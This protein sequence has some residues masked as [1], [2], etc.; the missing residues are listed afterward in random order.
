MNRLLLFAE[1]HSFRYRPFPLLVPSTGGGR[2]RTNTSTVAVTIMTTTAAVIVA[3]SSW[4]KTPITSTCQ[5][6]E[7]PDGSPY[8]LEV[9]LMDKIQQKS[10]LQE[11][12]DDIPS[13]LRLLAIDLP[14]LRTD[15]FS[16]G[17]ECHLVHE[18]VF[19]DDIAPPK[20]IPIP[21]LKADKTKEAHLGQRGGVDGGGDGDTTSAGKDADPTGDASSKDEG[22]KH[23]QNK[24]LLIAQKALVK[25]RKKETVG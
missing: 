17:S 8:R 10:Y 11:A 20:K 22:S 13:T 15:A 18:R 24:K 21:T 19:V 14:E 7:K 4:Y 2:A 3:A 12:K 23:K 5:Q 1:T 16:S 6:K 9:H 25:V